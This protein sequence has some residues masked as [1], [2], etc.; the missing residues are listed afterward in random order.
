MNGDKGKASGKPTFADRTPGKPTLAAK[1]PGKP[2]GRDHDRRLDRLRR[3]Y[4]EL[5]R[6]ADLRRASDEVW[7]LSRLVTRFEDRVAALRR[8]GYAFTATLSQ[9]ARTLFDRWRDVEYR[10]DRM[11]RDVRYDLQ[12]DLDRAGDAI[13]DAE[14]DP[15]R[16]RDAQDEL[17]HADRRRRDAERRL[18]RTYDREED[19]IR[20]LDARLDAVEWSVQQRDA[21]SF[22]FDDDEHLI[23]ATPAEWREP[24]SDEEI[25][26]VLFLT[27][28]S[29]AFEQKEKTGAFLGLFGGREQQE[30]KWR[31]ALSE[32]ADARAE[33]RGLFGAADLVHLRP[34][35]AAGW[36]DLSVEV[37]RNAD[38]Q[39]WVGFI[40]RARDDGFA[41]E[42]E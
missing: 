34:A 33:D 36:R 12:R 6:N 32:I 2:L 14:R 13:R 35:P 18:E 31:I 37:K 27:D 20:A 7:R 15:D 24:G 29:L 41:G 1:I 9:T 16:I 8:G 26:G 39:E 11:L 30:L 5:R 17:R 10:F 38:N 3:E 42:R 23:M 19:D 4:D 28:R 25:D 21:A 40:E 22:P